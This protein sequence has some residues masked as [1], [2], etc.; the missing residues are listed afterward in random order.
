MLPGIDSGE[1]VGEWEGL[2]AIF[3]SK[4]EAEK[5]ILDTKRKGLVDWAELVHHFRDWYSSVGS[6]TG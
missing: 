1:I 5:F 3:Q 6:V 2:P 4:T